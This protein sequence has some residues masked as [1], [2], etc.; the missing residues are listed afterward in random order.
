MNT[1]RKWL[2]TALLALLTLG[3]T[4]GFVLARSNTETK[5]ATAVENGTLTQEQADTKIK[6]FN[7][8]RSKMAKPFPHKHRPTLED[9][10]AKLAT[11]VENGTL[12]QEQADEKLQIWQEKDFNPQKAH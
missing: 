5:L 7:N 9:V 12:T 3:I 11:A 2:T 6:H 8:M 1:K 4:S 10:T